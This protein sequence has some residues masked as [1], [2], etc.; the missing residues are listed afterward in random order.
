MSECPIPNARGVGKSEG[1][2]A[3]GVL[4]LGESLGS[5]EVEDGGLP[6]RPHAQAGSVLERAITR[7][8]TRREQYVVF[9][10][11]PTQPPGNKI[12]G[13]KWESAAIEWGR[14]YVEEIIDRYKPRCILAT[15]AIPIRAASGLCGDKLSVSHL[16]GYVVPG[17]KD[18]YPPVV[19][20]FHPSYLRRGAM[21]HMSVLMR[22]LRLAI[23]VARTGRKAILPPTDN[24]PAGYILHPTE[25]QARECLYQVQHQPEK[26][27]LAYDIETHYSTDEEDAEEHAGDIKSIQF[28]LT[29]E[30]GIFMPWREPYIQIAK[31]ALSSNGRK[32]NWNGWRFDDPTLRVNGCEINGQ[33]IDLMWAWHHWQ[34]DLPRKLQFAAAMQGPRIATP[35]HSWGYP[36][37]HIDRVNP[38]FYGIVDVDVLQ[39]IVNYE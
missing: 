2:G 19:C 22:T 1:T 26:G 7:I 4:I 14:E 31:Q 30:T 35:S 20:T 36:W 10:A 8:G 9:N 29:P 16:A 33:I 17:V 28:S 27:W 37:K 24:P 12:A 32:I 34:P 6:Y 3:N 18:W 15:G 5:D 13:T 39:W 38:P 25:E 23:D 21:S 11:V